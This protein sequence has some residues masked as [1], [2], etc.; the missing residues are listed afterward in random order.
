MVTYNHD[1]NTYKLENDAVKMSKKALQMKRWR[2]YYERYDAHK[3]SLEVAK[4][5]VNGFFAD[6]I[7][8]I[9]SVTSNMHKVSSYMDCQ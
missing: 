6:Q 5:S 2:H 7:D 4:S 3:K 1:C 8:E 9:E